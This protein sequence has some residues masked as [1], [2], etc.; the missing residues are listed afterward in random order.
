MLS[1]A[2]PCDI[3]SLIHRFRRSVRGLGRSEM[4][5]RTLSR[6]LSRHRASWA[7]LRRCSLAP[8]SKFPLQSFAIF[9]AAA[10]LVSC[11]VVS[12]ASAMDCNAIQAAYAT[13]IRQAQICDPAVPDSCS[14]TRPWAPQDVCRCKVAVNPSST[15]QLDQLLAQFQSQACP[16]AQMVCNRVCVAPAHS[17]AAGA[18]PSPTCTGR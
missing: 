11:L 17:C 9:A 14:A 4:R 1:R 3:S 2:E 12:P 6:R 16:V 13:A 8:M 7:S 5:R 15:A 18:G 10:G